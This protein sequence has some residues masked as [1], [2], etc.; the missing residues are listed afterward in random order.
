MQSS[1]VSAIHSL[2]RSIAIACIVPSAGRKSLLR[3]HENDPKNTGIRKG[4]TV[5]IVNQKVIAPQQFFL[6]N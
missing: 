1:V 5:T 3:N 4:E 2:C 6:Q